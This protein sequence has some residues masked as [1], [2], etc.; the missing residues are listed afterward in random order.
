MNRFKLKDHL[1][2]DMQIWVITILLSLFGIAAVYSSISAL[3][4]RTSATPEIVLF[5][6]AFLVAVGFFVTYF[7]HRFDFINLAPLAKILL[8]LTPLILIYTLSSGKEVGGAKRW[9]SVFGWTFQTSDLVRLVLITNLSA[10]LARKQN[11]LDN[12]KFLWPIIIWC[13]V[14]CGLLA[15][16]SFSTSV[17]LGLT[18]LMIMI[19]GRVPRKYIFRLT[20]SVF[21][22]LILAFGAGL[23][24]KVIFGKDFGRTQTV[25]DRVEAF[26]NTDLDSNGL[27]GGMV[28]SQSIQQDQALAAVARGGIFGVGP[29]RSA[30]KHGMAESYSDFIYAIIIEEYGLIGGIFILGLYL[31][32]LARGFKNIENTTH[33]FG[34]L[35][36]IGLTLSI[37]FQALTH[38]FINVGL[39]P[40]TGQTLPL[41]SKGGTSIL[42]TSIALG[43]V[44]SVSKNHEAKAANKLR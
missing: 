18:C 32:L 26:T 35:L 20:G 27:I 43:I 1:Q 10:M 7:V 8:W 22:G 16:S 30:I 21:L 37:V 44:L 13:G 34:G 42:F 25:I 15:I 36:S 14:L 17:I 29:G 12:F 39:G 41:I 2:G 11:T 40:V 23:M 9:I 4:Y 24:S 5:K 3:V 19:I 28:G 38:M 33:A 6:H 31:W